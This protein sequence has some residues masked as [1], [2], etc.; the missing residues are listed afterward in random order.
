MRVVLLS[1]EYPPNPGGVGD[2][3]QCL[4]AALATRIAAIEV[5]TIRAGMLCAINPQIPEQIGLPIAPATWGWS[6]WGA[7]CAGLQRH[8]PDLLHIQYQTG[9]YHMHPALNLLPARLGLESHRPQIVVTAHDLFMP[10]LFPK[11]GPLRSWV[12]RRL[13]E[14][15]DATVVTNLED[16]AAITGQVQNKPNPTVHF[17]GRIR[18]TPH[19]IPIGSN[20]APNPPVGY[21]RAV[22][23]ATLGISPETTLV[24][25]FG[26]ISPTKGLDVL[27]DALEQLPANI[28]VLIVG[29]DS[30]APQDRQYAAHLRERI[31]SPA[32]A[33]RVLVTG[34]CTPP[35]VSAHL[36]AADIAALP[37]ADGAT[38][39]RGSL[40]A[41]LAHGLPTITTAVD[42]THQGSYTEQANIPA[43]EHTQLPKLVD[44]Q[45]AALIA[46]GDTQALVMHIQQLAQNPTQRA[47]LAEG[48]RTLAAAFGWDAIADRHVN[49]Y[50]QLIGK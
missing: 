5:W 12:T 8:K 1:A 21:N 40:L 2:Y 14:D 31:E 24:A 3:T 10:Y 26:L 41:A 36:L 37:F 27:L 28:R 11:A 33:G 29:G 35:D 9:A 6:A 20:I 4:S 25:Y 32:L 39:R 15:C 7:I 13:L 22:W 47:K 18:S 48:A 30:P 19:I 50:Q 34:H 46:I 23:R 38:F 16:F 43:P 44:Q 45:N 49:L 17:V 42:S